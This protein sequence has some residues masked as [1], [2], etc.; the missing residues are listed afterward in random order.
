MSDERSKAAEPAGAARGRG[1]RAGA[2]RDPERTRQAL[3]DAA[4]TEFAAKG[5]AGARVSEIA[6]RAGVN[7]QLISYHFDGKQGLYDA[8]AERWLAQEREFA[9]PSMPLGELVATYARVSVEQRDLTRLFVRECME[10]ATLPAAV[11]AEGA[12]G[13]EPPEVAD[14]RRRQQAGE[15]DPRLDPAFVMLALQGAASAGVS[16][17]GDVRRFTGLEPDSAEFAARYGEQLALL[18]GLLAAPAE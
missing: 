10:D 4:L 15:L 7:K 6:A 5:I 8:L 3:L 9:D 18:I 2:P 13:E 17:P 1:R 16:F 11:A 14:L 12:D